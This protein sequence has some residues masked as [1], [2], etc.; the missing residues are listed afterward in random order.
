MRIRCCYCWLCM[1]RLVAGWRSQWAGYGQKGWR[2]K[3]FFMCFSRL[4]SGDVRMHGMDGYACMSV[5]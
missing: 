5:R 4:R 3:V 2:A 1:L